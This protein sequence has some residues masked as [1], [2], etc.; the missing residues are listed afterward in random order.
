MIYKDGAKMSKSKGNVVAPDAIVERYGAD[1][2]RL[3]TLFMGPPDADKEWA[4]TGVLGPYRFL[5]R[6]WRLVHEVAERWAAARGPSCP[7]GSTASRSTSRA[8]RTGPIAKVTDDIERRFQFNTA[9]AALM[10]LLNALDKARGPLLAD[11]A[12]DVALR[13]AEAARLARAAVRAAR[14][15]GAVGAPRRRAPVAAV[16][17][18]W[19]IRR[20]SSPTRS[21]AWCR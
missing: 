11:A 20:C 8:R 6:L 18:P 16:R 14:R 17:G 10:E 1:A 2:L 7:P 4:D 3:Y 5:E 12:G 15:G 9:I 21:S 19:P 13:H